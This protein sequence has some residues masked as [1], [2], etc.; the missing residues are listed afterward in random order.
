MSI[1]SRRGNRGPSN[2]RAERVFQGEAGVCLVGFSRLFWRMS[3]ISRANL[4]LES[5]SVTR[6]SRGVPVHMFFGWPFDHE[7]R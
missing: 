3:C 6:S 1:S 5:D 2:P 4:E 7:R